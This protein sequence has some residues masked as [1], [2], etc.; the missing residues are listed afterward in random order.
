M[1]KHLEHKVFRRLDAEK[2]AAYHKMAA[3]ADRKKLRKSLNQTENYTFIPFHTY[4]SFVFQTF[5]I[6]TISM[7]MPSTITTG[8]ATSLLKSNMA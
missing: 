1:H 6:A 2:F 8:A 5:I 7:I 3:A 4:S